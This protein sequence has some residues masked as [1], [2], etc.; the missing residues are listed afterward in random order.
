ME[1]HEE[2]TELLILHKVHDHAVVLRLSLP[3]FT[4]NLHNCP[5]ER[6]GRYTAV[7]PTQEKNK[8]DGG[9]YRQT[10]AVTGTGME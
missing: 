6:R 9:L 5:C 10:E 7:G 1:V 4:L 3:Y 2:T 8:N